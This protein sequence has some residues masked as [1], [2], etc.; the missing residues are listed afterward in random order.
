MPR[1]MTPSDGGPSLGGS[2]RSA[3]KG[4]PVMVLADA[5]THIGSVCSDSVGD[6]GAEQESSTGCA[7][8]WA[9][10]DLDVVPA[11]FIGRGLPS[12]ARRASGA[13]TT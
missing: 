3:R 13:R 1:V 7:F 10:C 5:N 11:T 12:G 6:V 4:L 2:G 9:L 8:H